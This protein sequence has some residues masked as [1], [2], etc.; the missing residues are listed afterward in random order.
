MLNSRPHQAM[1]SPTEST[2]RTRWTWKPHTRP[3]M[4]ITLMAGTINLC[5]S[6]L[7]LTSLLILIKSDRSFKKCIMAM[8]HG[9]HISQSFL[10]HYLVQI[11]QEKRKYAFWVFWVR[12]QPGRTWHGWE[13]SILSFDGTGAGY[14]CCILVRFII[15]FIPVSWIWRHVY[16]L[17]W[18]WNLGES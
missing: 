13:I 17:K 15:T 2:I 9:D 10:K 12:E 3:E 7:Q 6:I 11:E 4:G 16:K 18:N 5:Q 8:N 1:A 14:I